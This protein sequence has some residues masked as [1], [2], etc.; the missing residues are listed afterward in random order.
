MPALAAARGLHALV[1]GLIQ[2][3]L[4]DPDAFRLEPAGQQ[5]IDAYLAGLGLA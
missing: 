1:D 4:L 5:A 2:N 3:W